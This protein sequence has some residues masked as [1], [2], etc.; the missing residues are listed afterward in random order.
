[1]EQRLQL[2]CFSSSV[3]VCVFPFSIWLSWVVC[4]RTP[5]S[6]ITCLLLCWSWTFSMI[7]LKNNL[8]CYMRVMY[9]SG[10]W[11]L[12]FGKQEHALFLIGATLMQISTACSAWDMCNWIYCFGYKYGMHLLDLSVFICKIMTHG[13]SPNKAGHHAINSCNGCP[14]TISSIAQRFNYGA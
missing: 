2:S 1:M 7:H 13:P 14:S 3:F 11:I 8:I 12:C 9:L 10:A 6:S 5:N 4:V